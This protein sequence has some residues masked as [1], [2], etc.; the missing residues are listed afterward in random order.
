MR[1]VLNG[2]AALKPKTGVGHHV[3]DL[4]AALAAGFPTDSFM[5][6]PG[7]TLG[8]WVARANRGGAG[9]VASAR[10]GQLR[11]WVGGVRAAG[12]AVAKVLSGLHFQG[13]TRA[14]PFDLYHEPNFV[15][16]RSHLPTVVT[17][18]DLSVLKF[19]Q[20]HPADRVRY[21]ERHFHSGLGLARHVIAV[22]EA[23][24]RE[25][26]ADM[27]LAPER[28]TAVHNG[29]APQFVPQSPEVV[30]AARRELDLPERFFLCVG[31]IEPRKNLGTVIRA[32]AD[33]PVDVR[34]NCP[35]ILAGPWGW[36]SEPERQLF[37]DVG[38]PAGVRQLGYVSAKLLPALYTAARVLLYPSHYE[39]FGLPPVEM[40]A[41]GGGVI[42][43]TDAAV[44]E[45]VGPCGKSVAPDDLPGWREAMRI[46]A[47]DDDFLSELKRGGLPRAAG[48]T[49]TRAARETLA[50]YR[51]VL[52]LPPSAGAA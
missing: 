46:A 48:F 15:P 52:G 3:A 38:G 43:S 16:F 9:G 42:V 2:L 5:L 41:C 50:V 34:S 10:T 39:G 33:L 19:P 25:L 20:W 17:V 49:W 6:Y 45:V 47:G 28:V 31:T 7:E 13:Y 18:H 23:I 24:R 36:R 22:S 21:H 30:A 26:I 35:L 1:V 14:F 8:G 32:F 37:D 27:G 4:A 44:R 12:K 29:V 51:S 11:R 40:L